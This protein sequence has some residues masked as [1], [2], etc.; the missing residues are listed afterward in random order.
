M[1]WAVAVLVRGAG[2]VWRFLF[3]HGRQAPADPAEEL[4]R[5]L[6]EASECEP[7]QPAPAESAEPTPERSSATAA[8]EP[9]ASAGDLDSYRRSVYERA[10]ELAEEMRD[11]N[12]D[13]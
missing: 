4:R 10:R 1:L 11:R 6:A 2:A 12:G 13:G 5:K 3:R 8:E 9:D 7:E